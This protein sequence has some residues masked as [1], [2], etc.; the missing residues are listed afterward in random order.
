MDAGPQNDSEPGGRE[1]SWWED[2]S[3]QDQYFPYLRRFIRDTL[4]LVLVHHGFRTYYQT[5]LCA[6]AGALKMSAL[7][8]SVQ[9]AVFYKGSY[10][11]FPLIMGFTTDV[12]S[13][14]FKAHGSF[15]LFFSFLSPLRSYIQMARLRWSTPNL[16]TSGI[17]AQGGI[18]SSHRC[19][20]P[21]LPGQ[22]R[23]QWASVGRKLCSWGS[24]P[25]LGIWVFAW[26]S[27]ACW[28]LYLIS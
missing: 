16:Q 11:S 13:N 1:S 24:H 10:L 23:S 17:L 3:Y 22:V 26:L 27:Q 20:S 4:F 19:I 2:F 8:P 18:G 5:L 6:G 28:E 7:W 25:P 15:C 14:F 12:T 9:G 21:T